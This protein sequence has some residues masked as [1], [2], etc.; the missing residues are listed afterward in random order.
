MKNLKKDLQAAKKELKALSGKM[1]KMIAAVGKPEK[2]KA[3]KAKPVKKAAEKKPAAKK[4]SKLSAAET[5]LRIIKRSR[6]GVDIDKL[7]E[8]SGFVGQKLHSIVYVLKKQGKIKAAEK[9]V[10]VKA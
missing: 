6:K 10:Y 9:G 2:P 5:V 4:T 8:K 1:E 7:K 3:T